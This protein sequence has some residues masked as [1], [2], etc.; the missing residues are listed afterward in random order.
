MGTAI[1]IK[2]TQSITLGYLS[3]KD[4]R[5][6]KWKKANEQLAIELIGIDNKL[7]QK[8]GDCATWLLFKQAEEGLKLA[9]SN[10]CRSKI[11]PLCSWRKR[12]IWL[13]R[14]YTSLNTIRGL[15]RDSK[16]KKKL[17]LIFLTL[18]QR[19]CLIDDL[20]KEI[21]HMSNAWNKLTEES[22]KRSSFSPRVIPSEGYFRAMEVTVKLVNWRIYCNVHYHV[23]LV[24]PQGYGNK[25]NKDSFIP[26]RDWVHAWRRAMQLDYDPT[27]HVKFTAFKNQSEIVKYLVKPLNYNLDI[28]RQLKQYQDRIKQMSDIPHSDYYSVLVGLS[29][30]LKHC[31]QFT[32][33]GIIRRYMPR[34]IDYEDENLINIRQNDQLLETDPSTPNLYFQWQD[35]DYH[36]SPI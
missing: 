2:N 24:A 10:F 7:S 36:Y 26:Q 13:Q 16:P 11:C 14:L 12:L 5:F 31:Q 27:A 32:T 17:S 33:G 1:S 3:P 19:N 30:Q 22:P 21:K 20:S 35:G 28:D 4:S 6:Q 18:S 25:E 23:I 9:S 29:E 34:N 8:L 15:Y